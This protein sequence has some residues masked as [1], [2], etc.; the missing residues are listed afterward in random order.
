[1]RL[2]P[3]HLIFILGVKQNAFKLTKVRR[4]FLQLDQSGSFVC[5]SE[6][7]EQHTLQGS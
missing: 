5:F 4:N 7:R 6:W 3:V 2:V 1:M